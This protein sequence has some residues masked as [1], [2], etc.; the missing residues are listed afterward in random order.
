MGLKAVILF[1]S[2]F[3][4]IYSIPAEAE[5]GR[6][7]RH[8]RDQCQD[9]ACCGPDVCYPQSVCCTPTATCVYATSSGMSVDQLENALTT[10]QAE[11]NRLKKRVEKLEQA[12]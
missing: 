9:A 10:L 5:A 12:K 7:K 8:G 4:G 1:G 2:I 3:T 6:C 11:H